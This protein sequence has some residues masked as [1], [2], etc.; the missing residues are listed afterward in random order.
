MRAAII[1]R[2][3]ELLASP[4]MRIEL[5]DHV[6]GIL[7]AT[8]DA[9]SADTFAVAGQEGEQSFAARVAAYDAAVADLQETVILLSRW[10]DLDGT[11]LLEKVFARLIDR[12]NRD[13]AGTVVWLRLAWYP[14]ALLLYAAGI[15]ALSARRY[16]VL[17][18]LLAA[19]SCPVEGHARTGDDHVVTLTFGTLQ[20]IEDYFKQLPGHDRHHVPRSEH[21]HQTLKPLFDELLFLGSSYE[22]LFDRFEVFLA[23]TFA[24]LRAKRDG[25]HI[26]GPPGRFYW[27]QRRD[28]APLKLLI[29]EASAAGDAWPPLRAGF[30]RG[31]AKRFID[32]AGPYKAELDRHSPF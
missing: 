23:L 17:R 15:A 29:G 19:P 9:L 30:F 4:A 28:D 31:D 8:L 25:D 10:G 27:K 1:A 12:A 6:T 20:Q 2:T 18:A 13:H 32:V 11:I 16:D 7:R 3:K 14:V 24:D 21:L 5:D 22:P 26:W